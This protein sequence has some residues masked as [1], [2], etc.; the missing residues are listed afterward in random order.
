M[1]LEEL[2]CRSDDSGDDSPYDDGD[3]DDDWY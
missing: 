1:S 2:K 3:D